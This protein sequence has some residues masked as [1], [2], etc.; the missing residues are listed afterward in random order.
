MDT[1]NT[2]PKDAVGT[3]K[4]PMSTVPA[5]VLFELGLAMLEGARKYGRHNYRI[6]GVR[7]SVYYDAAMRHL[8]SFW[9][10]NDTDPDSGG[11]LPHIIKAMAC[12]LVLR[13][14]QMMG[15]WIDDRPPRLPDGLDLRKLNDKASEIIDNYPD[16][17]EPFTHTSDNDPYRP[18]GIDSDQRIDW[19]NL[20]REVHWATTVPQPEP[21]VDLV[22][23]LRVI[24]GVQTDPSRLLPKP[25]EGE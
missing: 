15:N 5:P 16:A 1:K 2:N 25:K 4:A 23:L 10:G 7:A 3:R 12:L 11:N 8:A 19:L 14:S 6:S 21:K 17:A 13:D 9:E 20:A 18:R 22:A 24:D